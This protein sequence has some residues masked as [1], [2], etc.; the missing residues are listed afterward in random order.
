[1]NSASVLVPLLFILSANDGDKSEA[2]FPVTGEAVPELEALDTLMTDFMHEHKVPGA[3]L[4]VTKDGR[5]VYARGFGYSDV[6]GKK[7]VEPRS[8]FRLASVTKPFTGAAILQLIDQGKLRMD[9]K[10]FDLLKLEPLLEDGAK[11]DPRWKEVT[12]EQILHHRGGWDRDVSG[13]PMFMPIKI[14]K[15]FKADPPASQEQ[16][17]RY[18]MGK[19]LDHDPGKKEVYSNFGYCVLGRV[20]ERASGEKYEDYVK[21]H[22]LKPIGVTTMRLGRTLEEKRAPGEVKY[23]DRHTGK[24]VL[25]PNLGKQ[26]PAPYGAWNLEAMDAHGGWIAS[27]VDVARFASALDDAKRFPAL[28]GNF[29]QRAFKRDYEHRGALDGTSTLMARPN[30]DGVTYVVLFNARK[31][32]DEKKELADLINPELKKNA[33]RREEMAGG[34][35]VQQVFALIRPCFIN[36]SLAPPASRPTMTAPIS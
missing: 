17:I 5:L 2:K 25:G 31:G 35:L 16:I 12:V 29:T 34:R 27:A 1:M 6:E 15:A 30:I 7:P 28:G 10:V 36:P 21:K 20:I 23:Y 14:A 9:D 19:P 24:A 18:M 13:D 33:W 4:A 3:A 26:V 22:V 32:P 11:F 8:L